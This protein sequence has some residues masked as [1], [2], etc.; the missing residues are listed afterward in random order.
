LR[1]RGVGSGELTAWGTAACLRVRTV[2]SRAAACVA[3]GCLRLRSVEAVAYSCGT[4]RVRSVERVARSVG[5]ACLRVNCVEVEACSGVAACF[6]VCVET[7]AASVAGAC[8][9]VRFARRALSTASA[10]LRAL[11]RCFGRADGAARLGNVLA[12]ACPVALFFG[13]RGLGAFAR[14][15]AC[16]VRDLAMASSRLRARAGCWDRPLAS[17]SSS[18]AASA[19][20][21]GLLL[22]AGARA[23]ARA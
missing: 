2:R 12:F 14:P 13:L 10:R 21:S 19:E 3:A 8:L 1:V 18:L 6:S 9:R 11:S 20:P 17:A 16:S 23:G 4:A 5:T 15:C 7:M 22:S